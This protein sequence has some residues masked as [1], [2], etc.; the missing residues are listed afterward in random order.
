MVL[1]VLLTSFLVL[2]CVLIWCLGHRERRNTKSELSTLSRFDIKQYADDDILGTHQDEEISAIG[3]D[4]TS[5]PLILSKI[6]GDIDLN[7]MKTALARA[8][9]ASN[10]RIAVAV[11]SNVGLHNF[12]DGT[13]RLTHSKY[14]T[15]P[16]RHVLLIR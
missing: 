10:P 15:C 13:L 6:L 4:D 3:N 11:S 7:V 16:L 12:P 5:K 8:Q 9:M 1:L 14:L 2:I